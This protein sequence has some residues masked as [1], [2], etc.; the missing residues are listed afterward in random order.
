MNR[1]TSVRTVMLMLAL[2]AGTVGPLASTV[3][4]ASAQLNIPQSQPAM[5]TIKASELQAILGATT[6]TVLMQARAQGIPD[7]QITQLETQMSGLMR[8]AAAVVQQG[9]PSGEI[10]IPTQA[11]Q[12]M[13]MNMGGPGMQAQ[14]TGGTMQAQGLFDFIGGLFGGGGISLPGVPSFLGDGGMDTIID[15]LINGLGQA[16]AMIP[17]VGPPL[18]EILK[19]VGGSLKSFLIN[20]ALAGGVVNALTQ[21]QQFMDELNKMLGYADLNKLLGMGTNMVG[22][23]LNAALGDY[24][25]SV[26]L[27]DPSDPTQIQAAVEDATQST[28]DGLKG[29]YDNFDNDPYLDAT[30]VSKYTNPMAAVTEMAAMVGHYQAADLT[31]KGVRAAGQSLTAQA[32][33]DEIV[34]SAA[35]SV[36]TAA[37]QGAIARTGVA[38]ATTTLGAMTIQTGLMAEAN[39]LNAMNAAAVTNML[40]QNLAAQ[41][42]NTQVTQALLENVIKERRENAAVAQQQMK[43]LQES[44][45]SAAQAAAASVASLGELGNLGT[46]DPT[47]HPLPGP[48]GEEPFLK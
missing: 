13:T 15:Y 17:V 28:L 29:V 45:I 3:S 47:L 42:A 10:Q 24:G 26:V 33:G 6:Q 46:I 1:S 41:D 48:Y 23:R 18:A 9:T 27:S 30:G 19:Q 21:A 32:V 43:R 34:E 44:N 22:D 5:T 20:N 37:Q 39:N 8:Q 4:A 35:K 36:Q 2:T 14:A 12:A 38:S 16:I 40:R 31:N 11:L 7:A 25:G